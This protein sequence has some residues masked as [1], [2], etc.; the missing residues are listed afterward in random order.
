MRLSR[1]PGIL[2]AFCCVLYPLSSQEKETSLRQERLDIINYGIEG[3][4]TTLVDTL[5]NE[6]SKE[7]TEELTSLFASSRSV[8]VKESILRLFTKQSVDSLKSW[9]ETLLE[10]PWDERSST[11]NLA[12]SYAS[13]LKFRETAASVRK[14]LE[15]DNTVFRSAAISALGKIGSAED[16]QFLS[17]LLDSEI[18]GDDK[19]RLIVRQEIMRAL[20]EL[21]VEETWDRL[22]EI[23][24]NEDENGVIRA[25]A[26]EALARIGKERA[27]PVLS[28]LFESSDPALREAAISGASKLEDRDSSSLILDGIR[29]SYYKVRIRSLK[30]VKERNIT[31]ASD[32]AL[33]RARNDPEESVRL[34]AYDTL[35][36]IGNQE[37]L[38]WL[39]GMIRDEKKNDRYRAKA[40]AV[41]NDHRPAAAAP[42]IIETAKKTLADDKKT[43]LRYELGKT[44]TKSKDSR[45][46]ELILLYLSS[47]DTLTRSIGLDMYA[48]IGDLG[49]KSRVE[50]IAADTKQGALQK[51][52]KDMLEK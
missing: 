28:K 35:G 29:D 2:I 12:L 20:G 8:A 15:N 5:G 52:A 4:I 37:A 19:Q 41:L 46:S 49:S 3:D 32:L 33:F 36:A 44:V 34:E 23:A 25:T 50:E 24:E 17:D 40:A 39:V 13:A 43:W 26:A 30:A 21:Q 18:A 22:Y 14:I 27:Y 16:A 38:D 1:I 47:K 9:T 10:D 48:G 51:R 7:F 45:Y 31:E 42:A 11:V 6:E